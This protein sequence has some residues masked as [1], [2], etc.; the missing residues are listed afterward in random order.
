VNHLIADVLYIHTFYT[1]K[2]IV[3]NSFEVKEVEK[4]EEQKQKQTFIATKKAVID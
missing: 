3:A 1:F 4:T 2:Y